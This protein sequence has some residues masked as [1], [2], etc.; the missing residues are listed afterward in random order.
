MTTGS[1]KNGAV[2]DTGAGILAAWWAFD[3]FCWFMLG[4]MGI[5]VLWILHD[6]WLNVGAFLVGSDSPIPGVGL[7]GKIPLIGGWI[8]NAMATPVSWVATVAMTAVN[9]I[10]V[11]AMLNQTGYLTLRG[12]WPVTLSIFAV[13]S[14]LIELWVALLEHSVYVGGWSGL[15]YDLPIPSLSSVDIGGVISVCL[16]MFLFEVSIYVGVLTI[17]ALKNNK[18]RSKA[19]ARAK[20]TNNA[21]A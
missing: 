16:L 7:I 20:A 13:C 2:V 1:K 14:W 17:L 4:V 10:Q 21:G 15:V 12:K 9:L 8:A 11:L 5:T 18:G 6:P 19:A 3:L